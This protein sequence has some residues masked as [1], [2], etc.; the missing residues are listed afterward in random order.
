M[1]GSG[2]VVG[3]I[4]VGTDKACCVDGRVE[5]T[6]RGGTG[7]AVAD[8]AEIFTQEVSAKPSKMKIQVFFIKGNSTVNK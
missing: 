1:D 8:S 2:V 7:V 5:V 6:N 3:G 4:S